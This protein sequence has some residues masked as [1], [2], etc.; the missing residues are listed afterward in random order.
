MLSQAGSWVIATV[1]QELELN[2]P[3][4]FPG[5]RLKYLNGVWSPGFE[6]YPSLEEVFL[7]A[8]GNRE[9]VP[10]SVIS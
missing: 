1:S 6:C 3:R 4:N 5:L 7:R 8:L 2:L 9:S 10:I